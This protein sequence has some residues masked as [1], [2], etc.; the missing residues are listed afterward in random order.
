MRRLVILVLVL[1]VLFGT[2]CEWAY[3]RE[4]H[5]ENAKNGD[6]DSGYGLETACVH[7]GYGE[8][9]AHVLSLAKRSV[10]LHVG[11]SAKIG[12]T[13][14][15]RVFLVGNET[16]YYSGNVTLRA[17]SGPEFSKDSWSYMAGKLSKVKGLAVKITP[18]ELHLKPNET[19]EFQVGVIAQ[20]EGTYY[21][22][23]V[24]FGEKGWKSWDVIEVEVS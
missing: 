18:R 2:I 16:C 24:A 14:E 12:G 15:G 3:S 21:L 9:N 8:L 4:G 7:P 23:I 19:L 13:V 6:D 17:Y 20:K 1:I 5:S 11:E 22:Y 10:S